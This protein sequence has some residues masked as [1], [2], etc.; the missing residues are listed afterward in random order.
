VRF[1]L[2]SLFF[3]A[4]WCAGLWGFFSWEG[5]SAF[6]RPPAH[7]D[8]AWPEFFSKHVA[9]LLPEA[10]GFDFP[11]RPPNGDATYIA[12]KFGEEG[13]LGEDW[14]TAE[15]NKDLGEPVFSSADGW[16]SLA[17]DF[18]GAWGKVVLVTYRLG[19]GRWPPVVEMM[20]A[21][22]QE[23]DVEPFQ[24]VKRGQKIGTMGNA[25]GVYWAHLHWEVRQAP[26]IGL[27]GGYADRLDGWL[28]PSQFVLAHRPPGASP[29]PPKH[30]V[31]P[32]PEKA[33]T[34]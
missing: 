13:H 21:H 9:V 5:K 15:E 14:N 11:V 19:P 34:D 29:N 20:Y 22:L 18:E 33:G 16:V 31:L 23:I 26:G 6:F 2:L 28:D 7:K 12:R 1:R 4:V 25:S 10:D 17:M 32:K 30:R 3:L 8:L 27:G 24:F